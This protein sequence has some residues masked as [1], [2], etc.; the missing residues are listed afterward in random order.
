MREDSD[1]VSMENYTEDTQDLVNLA[2]AANDILRKQRDEARLLF[3]ATI[4]TV[5]RVEIPREYL[6]GVDDITYIREELVD[7][8]AILF[9]IKPK[10]HQDDN[11]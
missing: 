10:E 8:D 4:R 5:G 9:E 3:A 7:R 2:T 11:Q 6:S 1:F